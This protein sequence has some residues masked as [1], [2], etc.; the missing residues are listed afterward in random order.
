MKQ[1]CL[2]LQGRPWNSLGARSNGRTKGGDFIEESEPATWFPA[3]PPARRRWRREREREK[4]EG[5]GGYGFSGNKMRESPRWPMLSHIDVIINHFL[6][7]VLFWVKITRHWRKIL[8]GIDC[9]KSKIIY[10]V[11]LLSTFFKKNCFLLEIQ[12]NWIKLS[13]NRKWN[14]IFFSPIKT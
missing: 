4:G 6:F 12:W 1:P 14:K 3:A 10:F 11:Y 7:F 13:W 5:E 8:G 9:Q 2:L